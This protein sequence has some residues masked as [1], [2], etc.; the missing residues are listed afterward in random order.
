L[1]K[2][3]SKDKKIEKILE[4]MDSLRAKSENLYD[5]SWGFSYVVELL[6]ED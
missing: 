5:E 6:G 2:I 1:V 3:C 4:K